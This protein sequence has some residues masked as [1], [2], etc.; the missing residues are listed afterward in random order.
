MQWRTIQALVCTWDT[1]HLVAIIDAKQKHL[2]YQKRPGQSE[3]A[4]IWLCMWLKVLISA[5][6]EN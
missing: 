6:A 4:V 5:R 3:A 2:G 1:S